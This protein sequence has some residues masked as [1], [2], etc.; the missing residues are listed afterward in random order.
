MIKLWLFILF[1]EATSMYS[2]RIIF[3]HR[4][5]IQTTLFSKCY[6]MKRLFALSFFADNSDDEIRYKA[7][8]VCFTLV[9]ALVVK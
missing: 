2:M 9:I 8:R 5:K 1:F 7:V 6:Q 4:T 3:Y